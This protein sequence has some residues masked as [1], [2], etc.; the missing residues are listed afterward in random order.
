MD[1]FLFFFGKSSFTPLNIPNL[2]SWWDASSL[3]TITKDGAD[4]VSSWGDKIGGNTVTQ[5]TDANKP[6]WINSAI[7]GRPALRF[8]HDGATVSSL[9][10]ADATSL[11]YTTFHM[12]VVFSRSTDFGATETIAGKYSTTSPSAQREFRL[13]VNGGNEKLFAPNSINGSA[14]TA[15]FAGIDTVALNT[16][17]IGEC[18]FDGTNINTRISTGATGSGA[19]GGA[20]F[21]GTAP[22]TMGTRDG[23]SEPFAGDIAEVIFVAGTVSTFNQAKV[24]QYLANKYNI[25]VV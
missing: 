8:R 1:S 2:R 12:L 7:N 17:Y 6:K 23:L 25:A 13:A 9:T 16:P 20:I 19:T 4:L 24:R 18:W 3:S 15:S 5:G 22:F 21:Q 11:D 14:D 10:K